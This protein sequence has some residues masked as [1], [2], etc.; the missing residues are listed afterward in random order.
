MIVHH[1]VSLKSRNSLQVPCTA[2]QLVVAS[3]VDELVEAIDYGGPVT[4]L[5][6]GTNV[7]L[8]DW[9]PGRVIVPRMQGV[10]VRMEGRSCAKVQAGAGVVWHELVQT[11]L[12]QG[13]SG[14]E[15]LA[16]I[17]GLAG[18][19]P[20]QNIGAYGRELSEVLENVEVVDR[21]QRQLRRLSA[22]ECG[23][24]YR[25][26]IFR[27]V[28]YGRFVVTCLNLELRKRQPRVDYPGI[29]EELA[30][31]GGSADA[32]ADVAEAVMALR[33]RKLPDPG[34]H[35]NVGSFFKNPVIGP[36]EYEALS[37]QLV[38]QGFPFSAG[39]KVPA[40]RLIEA[41][42]WRGRQI[43]DVLVW[44]RQPLVL[45]NS[46]NARG[47]DFLTVARLIANDVYSKY[48]VTLELEPLAMGVKC[49]DSAEHTRIQT[50]PTMTRA[51]DDGSN[52]PWSFQA[53]Q[54]DS[55]D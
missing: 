4:I 51:V 3:S 1:L 23:F 52:K 54:G 29:A 42:G 9:I 15:N 49:T 27:D 13:I 47:S 10:K 2:E 43:G 5:G 32:G 17:P 45:V 26:S 11:T 33:R 50:H 16:L 55:R 39:I 22:E 41:A 35:P 8:L 24:G 48:G 40:A 7:V 31:I 21:Q 6:S 36:G 38:I 37:R 12:S 19:A 44:S 18:A 53:V 20:L 30:R 25:S 46:G 28:E 14:L 34:E